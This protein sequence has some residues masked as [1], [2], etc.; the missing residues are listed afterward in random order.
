MP[1]AGGRGW[2]CDNL[3]E[4]QRGLGPGQ[5]HPR[6][7]RAAASPPTASDP[8][9][10]PPSRPLV[11]CARAFPYVCSA[12]AR[13]SATTHDCTRVDARVV[14]DMAHIYRILHLAQLLVLD[15]RSPGRESLGLRGAAPQGDCGAAFSDLV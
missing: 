10:S 4:P 14:Q 15:S 8:R 6:P 11:A 12:R 9:L 3:F 5:S 13:A 2:W 1:L 7:P